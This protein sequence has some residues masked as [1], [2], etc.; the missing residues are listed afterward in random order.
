MHKFKL[1]VLSVS[2]KETRAVRQAFPHIKPILVRDAYC[3]VQKVIKRKLQ[4][5]RA[6]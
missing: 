5:H 2:L 3:S 1:S 4:F 6:G